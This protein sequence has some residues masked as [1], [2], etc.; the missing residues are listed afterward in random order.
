[1]S[2]AGAQYIIQLAGETDASYGGVQLARDNRLDVRRTGNPPGG[3]T[4]PG[5]LL[6][7]SIFLMPQKTQASK[8]HSPLARI[9]HQF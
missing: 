7:Q 2:I 9:F 4:P 5:K 1:L 3:R 8:A 6:V